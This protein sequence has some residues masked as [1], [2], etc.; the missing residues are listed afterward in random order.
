VE[1]GKQ[2]NNINLT[3]IFFSYKQFLRLV[4]VGLLFLIFLTAAGNT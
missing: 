3:K 2:Q 4:N 1:K